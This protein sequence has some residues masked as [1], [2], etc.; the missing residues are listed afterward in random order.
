MSPAEATLGIILEDLPAKETLDLAR[1]AAVGAL[2]NCV[3]RFID[4][5]TVGEVIIKGEERA[6]A[7]LAVGALA[8]C[9]KR[10]VDEITVGVVSIKGDTG[11]LAPI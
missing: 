3:K 2:A 6:L 8:T 10:W 1:A 5:I 4:E 9:V 11:A 7:L